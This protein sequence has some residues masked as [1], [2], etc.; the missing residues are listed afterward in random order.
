[1]F[2]KG[3]FGLCICP[4][5]G[6]HVSSLYGGREV[7]CLCL[8][9]GVGDL[10]KS[11]SASTREIVLGFSNNGFIFSILQAAKCRTVFSCVSL[12]HCIILVGNAVRC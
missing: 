11:G 1:M 10:L 2:L 6:A 4:S 8:T 9:L 12:C 7:C 3:L 5:E